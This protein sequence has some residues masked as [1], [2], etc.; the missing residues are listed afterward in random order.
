MCIKNNKVG[1]LRLLILLDWW[2]PLLMKYVCITSHYLMRSQ[3]QIVNARQNTN[4]KK[5]TSMNPT[6]EAAV[7]L[8][9]SA[10]HVATVVSLMLELSSDT[11]N[12]VHSRN[13]G[14]G[15]WIRQSENIF[16]YLFNRYCITVN[17]LVME[18]IQFSK[19]K[20]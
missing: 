6:Q 17:E 18:Y 1:T 4:R 20:F 7:G 12:L 5:N 10:L 9:D 11:F 8:A 15:L 13:R 19:I 3:K 16:R 14:Q 2:T